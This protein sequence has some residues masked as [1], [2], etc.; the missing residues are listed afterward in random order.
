MAPRAISLYGNDLH[1]DACIAC[2]KVTGPRLGEECL[3]A[4]HHGPS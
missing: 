3:Q 1:M 2:T 4:L